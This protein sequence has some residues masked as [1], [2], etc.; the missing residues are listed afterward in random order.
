MI[1]S[2]PTQIDFSV[3]CSIF[4]VLAILTVKWVMFSEGNLLGSYD[5]FIG[6]GLL[7]ISEDEKIPCMRWAFGDDFMQLKPSALDDRWRVLHPDLRPIYGYTSVDETFN[8]VAQEWKK[9][10]WVSYSDPND[11][12]VVVTKKLH[13]VEV[14]DVEVVNFSESTIT[15]ITIGP[16]EEEIYTFD[17]KFDQEPP[18][19]IYWTNG[20][21]TLE[22]KCVDV[23]KIS[24]LIL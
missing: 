18:A 12:T 8:I 16:G 1:K 19:T 6:S 20:E 9:R 22:Y 23:E 17:N 11:D 21:R 24:L 10:E 15:T 13:P 3:I 7:D 2:T 5:S 14:G 4:V